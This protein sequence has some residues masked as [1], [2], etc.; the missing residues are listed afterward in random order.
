MGVSKRQPWE[1]I[2]AAYDAGLRLFGENRVYEARD[3]WTERPVDAELHLV[4]QLQSNKVKEAVRVFST[5]QSVDREKILRAIDQRAVASGIPSVAVFIEVNTSGESTKSGVRDADTLEALV[6]LAMTL[7][8]TTLEGLMTIAPFTPEERPV[9]AAFAALRGHRDRLQAAYPEIAPLT[10]SMGMS[11][12][13][14]HAIVE[15][16]DLIRVGT[17]IFGARETL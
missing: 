13:L 4:G 7:E 5:I 1:R 12:D 2:R 9:R 10:L 3:K 14:E 15:G 6:A 11:D 17:A 16:S 8:R